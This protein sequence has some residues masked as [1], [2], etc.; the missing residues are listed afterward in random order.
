MV[1]FNWVIKV[2]WSHIRISIVTRIIRA[3]KAYSVTW[4][5]KGYNVTRVIRYWLSV[6]KLIRVNMVP[7]AIRVREVI[8]FFVG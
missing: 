4:V 8:G 6:F 5:I 3:I 1:R 2:S 7:R